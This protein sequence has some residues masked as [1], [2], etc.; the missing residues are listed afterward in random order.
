MSSSEPRPFASIVVEW[1]NAKLAQRSRSVDL[2]RMLRRQCEDVAAVLAPTPGLPPFELLL[3]FDEAEFR[4]A[5]LARLLRDTIG[6]PSAVLT[7]RLVPSRSSGYYEAKNLGARAATSENLVFIDSDVLPE[8]GWL[9]RMVSGLED[10]AIELVAGNTYIEP[11][12]LIGKVFAL[13]W[14]FPLR[15]EDGPVCPT[16]AFFANNLA[17]RRGV[18]VGHPFPE[19]EGTS[20]GSCLVLAK[21]LAAAGVTMV[22]DPGAR[23]GHPAPDGLW[24]F[25][26]RALA[27]GRDRV[28]RERQFG[29][30]WTAWWPASC[31][32]L[33]RHG[34][35][36]AR[37]VCTSFRAVG[38]PPLSI[39]GAVAVSWIYFG[40]YFA[41]EMLTHAGVAAIEKVRV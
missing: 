11:E 2:L 25:A 35:G 13:V 24:N 32:R 28:R 30:W 7:W 14:F 4:G 9:R 37:K 8:R 19:I 26:K 20:R 36:S 1:E 18:H 31:V 41:G 21:Q 23:A 5:E 6:E 33:C 38:L 27:Q 16:R 40:L 22:L 39:P 17:V 34:A 12:G 29:R 3:V 15:S 10:P